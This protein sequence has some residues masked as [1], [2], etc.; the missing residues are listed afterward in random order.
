MTLLQIHWRCHY[1]AAGGGFTP[2]SDVKTLT[3]TAQFNPVIPIKLNASIKATSVVLK[4]V[5][6][7]WRDVDGPNSTYQ[8]NTLRLRIPW[9]DIPP[10]GVSAK[11]DAFAEGI[12]IGMGR[13]N[14]LVGQT[15]YI[16]NMEIDQEFT[17]NG[18][19]IP[20]TFE[21]TTTQCIQNDIWN[22]STGRNPIQGDDKP[23]EVILY[24]DVINDTGC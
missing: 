15:R 22:P 13:K 7:A 1:I 19:Y 2:V 16:C 20:D 12:H 14:A 9:L 17:V 8:D 5:F 10:S 23:F 6:A 4:G 24:F 18:G 11:F 3:P 21:L